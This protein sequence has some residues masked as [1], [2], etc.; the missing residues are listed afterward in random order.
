MHVSSGDWFLPWH[1]YSTSALATVFVSVHRCRVAEIV[2]DFA[3]C[4]H[5]QRVQHAVEDLWLDSN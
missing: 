5:L 3:G 1:V 2:A 4:C